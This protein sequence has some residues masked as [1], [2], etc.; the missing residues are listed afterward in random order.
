MVFGLKEAMY[1]MICSE[2]PKS[3]LDIERD[4]IIATFL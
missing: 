3:N 4:V 2:F 1:I